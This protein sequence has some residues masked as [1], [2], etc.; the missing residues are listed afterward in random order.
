MPSKPSTRA[1]GGGSSRPKSGSRPTSRRRRHPVWRRVLLTL[2]GLGVLGVVGLGV[3]YALTDVPA[4]NE[5]AVAQ[6]S[7]VYYADGTTELDRIATVNRESISLDEVPAPVQKA[8][9]AAEDRDFYDNQGISPKG[10]ARAAWVAVRGGDQQGGS[11]IT[12]QYVKNYFLT[13]D[14]TL[15]RKFR[16]ILISVKVDQELSKDQILENYLNTIYFGRGAD[17]I[18]TAAQAYFGEDAKDLTVSQGALL[19]S[20]IRGP[21]LYDPRQG[22]DARSSAKA[23]WE[24]VMDGLRSE[25]WITER[26]REKAHFPTTRPLQTR[27]QSSGPTG[28]ITEEVRNELHTRLKLSDA[29][30]D[31]GGLKIVTTIDKKAQ[32]AAESAVADR[33][34]SG[35]STQL[36]AG[37]V[38][39]VPGNGAIRAMYGGAKAG[40]LNTAVDAT[41]Q[42]GSTFKIFTLVSALKQGIP[43]WRTYPA[44]SPIHLEAFQGSDNPTGEVQNFANHQYGT[45]DLTTATALSANTV[46]AP[47]N[48]EVGPD[49]TARAAKDAGVTTDVPANPANVFGTANVKVIDMANAYATIA[50]Q[51]VKA[52]PYLVKSVSSTGGGAVDVDY[53]ARPTTERVFDTDVMRDTIQAMSHVISP[54]GTGAYATRLGRP[55][56]GKT[57]T[58]TNNYAAW[59][60][61]FTPGQLATAVGIYAG[62]GS[63]KPANQMN[64]VPGVGE[65][66]GGTVPVQIWTEAMSGA[67]QGRPTVQLPPPGDV[68]PSETTTPTTS[69]STPTSTS[70]VTVPPSTTSSTSSTSTTSS[71]S[72]TSSTTSSGTSTTGGTGSTTTTSPSS[73]TTRSSTGPTTRTSTTGSTSSTGTSGTTSGTTPGTRSSSSRTGRTSTAASRSTRSPSTSNPGTRTPSTRT[74]S[75]RT[76]STRT[77]STR[78]SPSAASSVGPSAKPSPRSSAR[79]SVRSS[80]AAPSR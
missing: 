61:G 56:A 53:K 70:T 39:I 30:I 43:L 31:R 2:L 66:T 32:K 55:A 64:D 19:A 73:S 4:P 37:L 20:V 50:A 45:V 75:T 40:G 38:S 11:T 26:Q 78:R 1:S 63:Q 57:G 24:Y 15:T 47:L 36:H 5:A 14:R 67:L 25:G 80:A 21:S 65:L 33:M 52:D 9:L 74:T 34:P 44:N 77:T 18:Q 41:M 13:Q 6:A 23:R 42:A 17:G 48:V 71:T 12:Q 29:D 35:G 60:D 69:T 72:S 16:E 79:S 49:A 27:Q 54:E 8:F 28:Y 59:F 10:I 7:V 62:D 68:G 46:F 76:T 51:G 3:A 58:T 22:G